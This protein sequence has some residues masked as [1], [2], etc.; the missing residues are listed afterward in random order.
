MTHVLGITESSLISIGLLV[1]PLLIGSFLR[2]KAKADKS[3]LMIDVVKKIDEEINPVLRRL[4]KHED[5]INKLVTKQTVIDVKIDGI[6]EGI[7]DIK[8]LIGTVFDKLDTK[9]DK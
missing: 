2:Y 5:A 6:S 9:K 8:K 3:E 7:S 1:F 4:Q